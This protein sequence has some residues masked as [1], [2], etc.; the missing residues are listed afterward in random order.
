MKSLY[1][2]I[3]SILLSFNVSLMSNY[4]SFEPIFCRLWLDPAYQKKELEDLLKLGVNINSRS[5]DG[6]TPL[7]AAIECSW[8]TSS[9]PKNITE[10]VRFLLAHGAAVNVQDNWGNTPLILTVQKGYKEVVALHLSKGAD[11]NVQ[12]ENGDAALH[13]AGCCDLVELLVK[14]KEDVDI[15]NRERETPL[16]IATDHGDKEVVAL[17]LD[18][19]ANVDAQDIE[20]RTALMK[21]ATRGYKDIVKVLLQHK[22]NVYLENTKGE[23]ALMLAEKRGHKVVAIFLEAKL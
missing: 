1:L 21:A 5:V 22:A 8:L 11:V 10:I 13:Y 2:S 3:F 17:L 4:Y 15:K 20:G 7:M 12:N 18:R 6:T 19:G 23:T 16:M 14:S 9:A